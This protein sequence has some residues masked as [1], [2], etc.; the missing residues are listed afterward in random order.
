MHFPITAQHPVKR[1]FT[2]QINPFICQSRH[3]LR[4]RQAGILRLMA[5]RPYLLLFLH[6]QTVSTRSDIICAEVLHY[7]KCEFLFNH[8]FALTVEYSFD[9]YGDIYFTCYQTDAGILSY[10]LLIVSS[11]N[12]W[13]TAEIENL[14]LRI[15]KLI[16]VFSITFSSV[17]K[18]VH[19][20]NLI[21]QSIFSF[22]NYFC[23][24]KYCMEGILAQSFLAFRTVLNKLIYTI[25]SKYQ[26]FSRYQH[27][28]QQ[29]LLSVLYVCRIPD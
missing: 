15:R 28:P 7:L 27:S 6:T 25:F 8:P 20:R 5:E 17:S 2:G 3:D 11:A 9:A 19:R 13:S 1:R 23:F 18:H 29:L 10:N 21:N 14:Q 16:S 24:F 26:R 22:W 12:R 4:R